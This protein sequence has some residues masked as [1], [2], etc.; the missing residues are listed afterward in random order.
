MGFGSYI[1]HEYW[2]ELGKM[3]K[4]K[5]RYNKNY[6]L[7]E[8]LVIDY[9]KKIVSPSSSFPTVLE[10]GCGF[11][12]ITKLLLSNFPDVLEYLAIDL[13]PDQIENAKE[14]VRSVIETREHNPIE[15]MVSDIQSFQNQKR[16][17]LVIASEVLMHILP[18]EIEEVMIKL[19]GMS[20]EHVVNIDWYEQETPKKAA[21]HNFI[22]EYEKIYK[23]I[24]SIADV[25]RVP[26][27]KKGSWLSSI[28]TKQSIFHA[29]TKPQA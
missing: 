29:L 21:P 17:D 22:H 4:G 9:L 1:P 16:Y 13:S 19:V 12:R 5:F 3:Y 2:F 8:R 11:G 28:D 6:E 23:N 7:Q 26:I 24:P 14:F 25:Y 20:N 27:V 15:F 18:S 10:I